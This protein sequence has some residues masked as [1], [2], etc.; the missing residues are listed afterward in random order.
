VAKIGLVLTIVLAFLGVVIALVAW[1]YPR[2]TSLPSFEG[3]VSS[4]DEVAEFDEFIT[5]NVGERVR[6][7]ATFP[8]ISTV[9]AERVEGPERTFVLG[10]IRCKPLRQ[11]CEHRF[12]YRVLRMR[13]DDLE[14]V[15]GWGGGQ[16]GYF[17]RGTY[18]VAGS[19]TQ[20]GI[21]WRAIQAVRDA[22]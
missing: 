13:E 10:G 9:H 1:L 3:A 7:T 8:N 19:G 6:I 5:E 11:I 22:A 15:F 18:F 20:N 14:T 21:Q 12:W 17:L 16:M 2:S 4:P